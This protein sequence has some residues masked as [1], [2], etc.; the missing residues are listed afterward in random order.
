MLRHRDIL[1][2]LRMFEKLSRRS[3]RNADVREPM[4]G[5]VS[6]QSLSL[7]PDIGFRLIKDEWLCD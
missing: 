2:H 3:R 5:F 7:E 6:Q 1:N 4:R